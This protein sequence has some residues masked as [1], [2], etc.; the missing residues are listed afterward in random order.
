MLAN[1]L[2]DRDY[3]KEVKLFWVPEAARWETLRAQAKQADIGKRI[4]AALS[5]IEVENPK[6]KGILDKRYA[7]VMPRPKRTSPPTSSASTTASATIQHWAIC[8]PPSM[9]EKWQQANLL[10]CSKLLDHRN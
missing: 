4:D 5:L 1:E 8:R 7:R 6:L 3:Y 2:E 10:L 9:N